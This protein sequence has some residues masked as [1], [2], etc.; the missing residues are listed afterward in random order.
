MYN[1]VMMMEFENLQRKGN[2]NIVDVREEDEY[3]SE[4][5]E[6]S[7]HIPLGEIPQNLGKFDKSQ[8]YYIICHSGGRSAI[9]SK[10]LA[11]QGFKVVNVMGGMSAYRGDVVF[12]R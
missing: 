10:Y 4:H 6:G 5:I 1:S 12:G 7:I 11:E 3:R 2:L 8:E 9:A